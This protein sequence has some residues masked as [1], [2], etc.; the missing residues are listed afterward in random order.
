MALAGSALAAGAFLRAYTNR[1]RYNVIEV[2]M[3][4]DNL[5]E[6]FRG[7]KIAHIS[8]I[9]AGSF[10]RY[11]SVWRGIRKLMRYEPDMICFTGDL[12]NNRATEI[13][14][15]KRI[16]SQLKAPLGVYSVLGNHD[17]G[18]YVEWESEDA[19]KQN[20]EDLK[21]HH[22][23][24]GWRLLMNEHIVLERGD[25]KIAVMGIEN[26]GCVGNFP[27]YG[28]MSAACKGIDDKN[29]PFTVL[30]S[31]D[32]SHWRGQVLDDFQCV[33]LMLAGHTHGMQLGIELPGIE[34][35]PIQYIYKEWGGLYEE[36][37]KKLYV[38][39]GYGCHENVPGR[40]GVLP[41]IT[42]IKLT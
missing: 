34:W 15:Y 24:M 17:Y 3:K 7:M 2:E 12:V 16:F 40:L 18:D 30:L 33:D 22:E 35:S 5:P 42:I 38:N 27:Q 25:D 14:P 1:Y 20:L 41:E 6:S 26:W 37:N 10:D 36:G 11:R 28:D 8:D 39:R 23:D 13:E 4:F 21:Q 32:P 29:I 9:H 19:K 31:H